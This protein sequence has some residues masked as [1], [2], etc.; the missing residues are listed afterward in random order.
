MPAKLLEAEAYTDRQTTG[1]MRKGNGGIYSIS[2]D[3]NRITVSLNGMK[4]SA[5]Y[6]AHW[7]WSPK[8]SGLVIGTLVQAKVDGDKL[9]VVTPDAKAIKAKIIRRELEA[10]K[11]SPQETPSHAVPSI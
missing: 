10:H 7:S 5:I 11:V 2:H 4:I 3:M 9:I 1:F 8:A 6:E